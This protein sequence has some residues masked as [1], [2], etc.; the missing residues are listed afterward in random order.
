[1]YLDYFHLDEPPF[2]ITPNPDFLYLGKNHEEGLAHLLY[3]LKAEDSFVLLT[4]EAGTGKTT[5]SRCLLEHTP[6]MVD[7]ALIF[8]PKLSAVELVASI[9]D[10]LEIDYPQNYPPTL[11]DLIDRLN[12]RLL[13]SQQQGRTTQVIIDEAQNLTPELLEQV[14]LLTN[15]ETRNAKLLKIILLG[16]P[17]LLDMLAKNE[18]RQLTQRITARHHLVPLSLNDTFKYIQKR[19]K[20][21]GYHNR[22]PLF[23]Q[24][25]IF[26][27]HRKS[28]G[29]PRLINQACDRA[30]LGACVKKSPTVTW[31]I[32]RHATKEALSLP[33]SQKQRQQKK[34]RLILSITA[35]ILFFLL[36]TAWFTPKTQTL[37]VNLYN[38]T[39]AHFTSHSAPTIEN[40]TP[41]PS[42]TP[43]KI[44]P[45]PILTPPIT[46]KTDPITAPR[47]TPEIEPQK[48][49]S[50]SHTTSPK[51]SP[52]PP[53]LA[54][55]SEENIKQATL[56]AAL[57]QLYRL[58]NIAEI[59][60]LEYCTP[61]TVA[62][63]RC[64]QSKIPW[65][66]AL[67]IDLPFIVSFSGKERPI[68][69]VVHQY[70]PKQQ[71][72]S[73]QLTPTI[74]MEHTIQE[75][76][77]HALPTFY[78]L[79]RPP[80][81]PF[82][83]LAP[84]INHKNVKQLRHYIDLLIPAKKAPRDI[85]LFDDELKNRV[86]QFQKKS[87]LN[88][89]GLAGPLTFIRLLQRTQSTPGEIPSLRS[90]SSP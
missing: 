3:S 23:T 22:Q 87:R 30:L 10:D 51:Y 41:S 70:H 40:K 58:W 46:T 78:F 85:Y 82:L 65:S 12:H 4:G 38:D 32:A 5:L 25:A 79:W 47:T 90:A 1:M 7:T 14:R 75:I 84:G 63:L 80:N 72:I 76:H 2:S 59:P 39:K 89:D 77:S 36:L 86:I 35:I 17:E 42:S 43:S 24:A 33:L 88:P 61:Q 62:E 49:P 68:Y 18:L 34:Q 13:A 71:R 6:D 50:K 9:C 11:K 83:T 81:I 60:N 29:I 53:F 31:S 21:A 27:I 67:S 57:K 69:M 15:L 26:W 37:I 52:Y 20:K 8:N 44:D 48:E 19:L 56:S 45:E 73:L 28:K 74:A 66:K 64:Q 16:Q 54:N 55:Q